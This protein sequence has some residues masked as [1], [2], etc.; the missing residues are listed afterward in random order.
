MSFGKNVGVF[1]EVG[2][3]IRLNLLKLEVKEDDNDF[4]IWWIKYEIGIISLVLNVALRLWLWF[5]CYELESKD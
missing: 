5:Q 4:G 1:A 2:S 3:K